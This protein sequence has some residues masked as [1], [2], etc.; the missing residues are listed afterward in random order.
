MTRTTTPHNYFQ[1][2]VLTNLEDFQESPSCL[3]LGFNVCV[4]AYHLSEVIYE[5]YSKH[6]KSVVAPFNKFSEYRDHLRNTH[7][8]FKII[9][10][11]TQA[12][13]HL[14]PT[15]VRHEMDSPGQVVVRVELAPGEVAYTVDQGESYQELM[16]IL[17]AVVDM[18]REELDRLS[19]K[20]SWSTPSHLMKT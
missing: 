1:D 15:N 4:P 10:D 13:K 5:Y 6:D 7:A 16:P 2:F 14:Y 18:W 20:P 9:D 12:Y 17:D 8:S 19:A 11:I 3:H